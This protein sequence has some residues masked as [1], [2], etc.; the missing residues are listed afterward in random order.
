MRATEIESRECNTAARHERGN[1]AA[2]QYKTPSTQAQIV[3]L[4]GVLISYIWDNPRPL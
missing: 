3:V 1:T 2:I 4:G